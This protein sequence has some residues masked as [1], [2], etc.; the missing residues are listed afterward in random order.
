MGLARYLVV[1]TLKNRWVLLWGGLW[2]LFWVAMG[3]FI[4]TKGFAKSPYAA[5]YARSYVAGWLDGVVI[6]VVAAVSISLLYSMIYST[7]AVPYLLRF[8]RL[9]PLKYVASYYGA[10]FTTS[11]ILV[12]AVGAANWLLMWR[13]LNDSGISVSLADVAPKDALALLHTAGAVAVF[14]AFAAAL[15]FLLSLLA[16]KAVKAASWLPFTPLLFNMLFYFSYL[17][18]EQSPLSLAANP[19]TAAQALIITAYA[20]LERPYAAIASSN[21]LDVP[22]WALAV[23]ISG[24]AAALSLAAA[25]LVS[26]V[27][28]APPDLLREGI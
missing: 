6:T 16:L 10:M 26:K 7:A 9:R 17:Y 20:G 21:A 2:P 8:G 5:Q 19:F 25:L 4:F 18:V 11:L 1:R 24:W 14:T 15:L 13:G 23:S 27:R 22:V 12:A 28:Y 3:A